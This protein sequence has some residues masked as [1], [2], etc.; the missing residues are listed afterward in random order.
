M[1]KLCGSEKMDKSDL[2][3]KHNL[4]VF[5]NSW[6]ADAQNSRVVCVDGDIWVYQIRIWFVAGHVAAGYNALLLLRSSTSSQEDF[7]IQGCQWL[8][9]LVKGNENPMSRIS[10]FLT[11]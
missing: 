5:H 10:N 4:R 1:S 3:S 7:I 2:E 9:P 11:I 8:S 6:A